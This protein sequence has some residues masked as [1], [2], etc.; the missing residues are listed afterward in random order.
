MK[1]GEGLAQILGKAENSGVDKFDSLTVALS[2]SAKFAD[3][4]PRGWDAVERVNL[5]LVSRL[6]FEQKF[7][8]SL[9]KRVNKITIT[10]DGGWRHGRC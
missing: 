2:G 7:P 9:Q 10:S 1:P 8:T 5:R 6:F 3:A 4:S